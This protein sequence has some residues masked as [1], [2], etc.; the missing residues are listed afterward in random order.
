[1]FLCRR[2]P[3]GAEYFKGTSG[4]A[5]WI[6]LRCI[7]NQLGIKI[8]PAM[9]PLYKELYEKLK[10]FAF[11][12]TSRWGFLKRLV[13]KLI[14]WSGAASKSSHNLRRHVKELDTREC[15]KFVLSAIVQN[16]LAEKN[17]KLYL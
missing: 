16:I 13:S 3:S 2:K 6:K 10:S 4:V 1:M 9:G 17:L 15:L 11:Q 7:I 12:K 5:F 14:L 8:S